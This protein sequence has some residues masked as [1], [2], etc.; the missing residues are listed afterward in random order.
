MHIT[1]EGPRARWL[2]MGATWAFVAVLALW[3]TAVMRDYVGLLDQ[4]GRPAVPADLPMVRPLPG[5][6]AD[7]QA[8]VRYALACQEGAPWQVRHTT[9]DNAPQGREVHWNSA[10]V[11]AVSAAGRIQHSMTGQPLPRATE[12]ALAWFN[13]PLLLLCV[14]GLSG[15]AAARAGAG[16]GVLVALA[17]V[18]LRSF[19]DGFTPNYVDHHGLLTATA[20]GLLLGVGFMGAGWRQAEA[21]GGGLFPASRL[22]ARRAAIGSALCGAVGMWISAAS[23]IPVIGIAGLAGLGV[24]WIAG[25]RQR[26]D[27]AVFDPSVWRWWGGTGAAACLGFYLLEYAPG[28]LGMRLEVNHPFHALAWWGGSE[29]I[30]VIGGWRVDRQ[31]HPLTA[32]GLVPPLLAMAFSPV[33]VV[34]GGAAVFMVRD[35][36]VAEMR[37]LVGEGMSFRRAVQTFGADYVQQYFINF[38]VLGVAGWV[39]VTERRG[40]LVVLFATAVA[41]IF[42]ALAC[43]E[44]RW[45]LT[46]SAAMLALIVVLA[47]QLTAKRSPRVQWLILLAIGA[48]LLP[49]GAIGGALRVRQTLAARAADAADLLQPIYRDLAGALRKTQPTGPIVLLANP[50][51]SH[52]ISYYG[53][54][55]SVGTLYWENVDGL[56][57][58]AG[59]YAAERDEDARAMMRAH[60]VTHVVLTARGDFVAD[61]FSLLRA[62]GSGTDLERTFGHRVFTQHQ[63]PRWLKAVPY[64]L[65]SNVALANVDVLIL[66]VV[67]EQSEADTAWALAVARLVAGK[68]DEAERHFRR[69]VA[70]AA[71]TDQVA[72]C[73]KAGDLAL[74]QNADALALLMYRSTL[75]VAAAPA[76]V[77]KVAWIMATSSAPALRNGA[78]AVKLV[79]P[80]AQA[81]PNDVMALDALAAALAE[82]GRLAEAIQV[83]GRAQGVAQAAGNTQTLTFLQQRL[84]AYRAGRPWRR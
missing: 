78:E 32:R 84:E 25:R 73:L 58:A 55:S 24:T 9:I 14:V 48:V 23:T 74:E 12:N 53:G 27:E 1:R 66:Q 68:P 59:I 40:R 5:S 34:I 11:H 51:A 2:I 52:S 6:F 31:A 65:P 70:A 21:G 22:A 36:F 79:T 17:M 37:H 61:Y 20:A 81:N 7:A 42:V 41:A 47:A 29:L 28:H 80:I 75:T 45:W 77:M 76:T 26:P 64:R 4:V 39:A 43:W 82:T 49:A 63:I 3:H 54:F 13:L 72:L 50:D 57:A 44:I 83:L 16:A 33:A 18:G 19:Y 8:W 71:P 15:W 62:G 56:K 60:G 46:V 38:F 69:A 10:F 67:P 30:A 35:P